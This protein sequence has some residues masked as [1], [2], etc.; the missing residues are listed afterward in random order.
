[1]LK[2]IMLPEVT[3]STA[4]YTVPERRAHVRE[5]APRERFAPL[6]LRASLILATVATLAFLYPRS[7]IES[8]LRQ[9]PRPDATTLAYLR[10][11]VLAQPTAKDIRTLL[12]QQALAA[13]DLSLSR[14]ALA[15]WLDQAIEAVPPD[16]ALLRLRLLRS[17]LAAA[18]PSSPRHAALADTYI[19]D[20]LLLAPRMG[21]SDLLQVARIVAALGQYRTAARLYRHIIT[22]TSDAALRLEAFHGGIEA[23]LAAGRPV[24]ALAFAQDELALVPASAALWRE[25]T[26]LALMADAGRAAAGYARRLVGLKTP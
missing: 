17:E 23:L 13:G 2:P 4:S 7:Y 12:A 22:R 25:M 3:A 9:E 8:S 26:R 1:M 5:P 14:Y 24:D 19:R 16:V 11:M 15:P 10:L 21:S 20:V 6:W 18:Q